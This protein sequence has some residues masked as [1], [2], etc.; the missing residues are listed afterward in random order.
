[1]KIAILGGTGDQGF[2]LALRFS[3]NHEILIGSRKAEKA[4]EASENALKI[5][6]EK[7]IS[8]TIKGL[9]NSEASKLADV[10]I[11]SLPFEYTISTLKEL[12]EELKGKIVVSIGV[13]LATAIG[14]KPTRVITCPQGSVA[15][16]IQEILPES[17]VV[18]G[19]QNICSKCLEDLDCEVNCDVLIAGND[20]EAKKTVISLANE[21]PGIRGIDA[22]KLEISKFIEQ[23]TPLLIQLNIKYKLKGA[24]I[25]ITGLNL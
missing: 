16:L 8:T 23:I 12:K 25:Q 2:G 21:I 6:S 24:G 3:K 22:G 10:V 18:S 20:V 13:P 11:V 9:T 5:L 15:E 17:K 7:K 4:V 19:F 14:D 1:M